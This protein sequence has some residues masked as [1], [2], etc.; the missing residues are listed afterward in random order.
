[1]SKEVYWVKHEYMTKDNRLVSTIVKIVNGT[2]TEERIAQ[3]TKPLKPKQ[4]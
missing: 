2:P 4:R 1:M 3:V